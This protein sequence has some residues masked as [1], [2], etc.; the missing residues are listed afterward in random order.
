[1]Q[2]VGTLGGKKQTYKIRYKIYI[3]LDKK[4]N[5]NNIPIF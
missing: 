3:Y 1:M 2:F 4:L 5:E